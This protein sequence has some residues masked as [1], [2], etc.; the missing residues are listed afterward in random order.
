[1]NLTCHRSQSFIAAPAAST[2][3]CVSLGPP[4]RR[5]ILLLKCR[6]AGPFFC[7]LDFYYYVFIFREG[8]RDFRRVLRWFWIMKSKSQVSV[9]DA[10]ASLALNLP[11]DQKG[12]VRFGFGHQTD[13][14]ELIFQS[15]VF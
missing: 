13:P 3:L 15:L 4:R 2:W 1:M 7:F 14:S 10:T 6:M 8:V 12:L 9:Y 5:L 11:Q